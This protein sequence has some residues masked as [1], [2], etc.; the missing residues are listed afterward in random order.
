M[1]AE[2]LDVLAS[3]YANVSHEEFDGDIDERYKDGFITGYLVATDHQSTSV[4]TKAN[5]EAED[6]EALADEYS[7]SET[8][9]KWGEVIRNAF[10]AG[11][12]AA[13]STPKEAPQVAVEC[14]LRPEVEWFAR[15]MEDK[16]RENDFKGGWK[17]DGVIE[18]WERLDEEASELKSVLSSGAVREYRTKHGIREAADVAN[19]AMMIADLLRDEPLYTTK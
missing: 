10:I 17:N 6:V 7:L 12:K 3:K 2:E 9:S 15:K 8:N 11:Y 18:L 4:S 1:S 5:G 19:F 13:Q 14:Y 16:L